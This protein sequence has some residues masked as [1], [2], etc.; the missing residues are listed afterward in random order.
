MPEK[1]IKY[2]QERKRE[3]KQIILYEEMTDQNNRPGNRIIR[4]QPMEKNMIGWG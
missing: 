2:E 3:K 4:R 1:T